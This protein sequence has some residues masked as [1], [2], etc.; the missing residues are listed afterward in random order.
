MNQNL[1][2]SEFESEALKLNKSHLGLKQSERQLLSEI[3]Q[4]SNKTSILEL[5]GFLGLTA[6]ELS[7]V[8]NKVLTLESDP[9]IAQKAYQL[10]QKFQTT[11]FI[12]DFNFDKNFAW[13]AGL[14]IAQGRAEEFIE[15][16]PQSLWSEI[17]FV[18]VDANKGAY[19]LYYQELVKKLKPRSLI[20]FDNVFLNHQIREELIQRVSPEKRDDQGLMQFFNLNERPQKD[21]LILSVF[22]NAKNDASLT[23]SG[24]KSPWSNKVK[25]GIFNLMDEVIKNKYLFTLL[26]CGD[27]FLIFRV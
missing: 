24:R 14:T 17:D 8:S 4:L 3:F 19:Y 5:G 1:Y 2:L 22:E 6:L 20:V 16:T 15:K 25:M 13:G 9:L 23:E 10:C 18:F 7:F 21:R 27:G 11:Y 12:S 26:D